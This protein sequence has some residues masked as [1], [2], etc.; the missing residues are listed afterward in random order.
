[1]FRKTFSCGWEEVP[2][3]LTGRERNSALDPPH[4]AKNSPFWFQGRLS[5]ALLIRS[6]CA[7][8]ETGHHRQSTSGGLLKSWKLLSRRRLLL[9]SHKWTKKYG[10]LSSNF[11]R[12]C[13]SD[14]HICLD[15]DG[16]AVGSGGRGIQ[17][18]QSHK[19]KYGNTLKNYNGEN[20]VRERKGWTNHRALCQ[21][22]RDGTTIL[23]TLKQEGKLFVRTKT[24]K[25]KGS[26]SSKA[27][28]GTHR[29]QK[30]Q[31][32]SVL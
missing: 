20:K 22:R 27:K 10:H 9:P 30:L 32:G 25:S 18:N 14:C 26:D 23:G 19:G 5:R 15:F 12:H 7:I 21:F 24:E 17:S 4:W 2:A 8:H 11:Q 31:S 28:A 29:N 6:E 3:S 13:Q 16:K 1:M